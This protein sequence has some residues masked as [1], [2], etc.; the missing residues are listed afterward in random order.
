VKFERESENIGKAL[1]HDQE[2][3]SLKAC[4]SNQLLHTAVTVALNTTLR[5]NEIRLLRWDQIDFFKRTLRVGKSKTEGGS[6]REI[7]LNT[8]AYA[9]LTKW[10]GHFPE[11]K[12]ED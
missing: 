3:Q 11:S 2:T 10:A 4:E 9:A 5:K 12:A 7:P 6:G 1:T 8:P